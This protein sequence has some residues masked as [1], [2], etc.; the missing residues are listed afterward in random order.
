MTWWMIFQAWTEL[1]L[2]WTLRNI[3]MVSGLTSGKL[4]NQDTKFI[5]PWPDQA[6]Y[7][8]LLTP[9][10]PGD[11][12]N[13]QWLLL[14]LLEPVFVQLSWANTGNYS[15]SCQSNME[16]KLF[17]NCPSS[18]D[19]TGVLFLENIMSVLWLESGYTVKFSL[20]PWKI[21]WAQL[22]LYFLSCDIWVQVVI[23]D[24]FKGGIVIGS[25]CWRSV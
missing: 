2:S 6:I 19:N 13:W 9:P 16:N 7:I 14:S 1:M 11:E 15:P 25:L 5:P 10:V 24:D 12:P 22:R 4:M 18:E 21:P 23:L 20:S 8:G 17:Q 3:R